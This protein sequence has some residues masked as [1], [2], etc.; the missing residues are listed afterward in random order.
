MK[1]VDPT[2]RDGLHALGLAKRAGAVA[3]GTRA[4]MDAA[5][6]GTLRA[7]IVSGDATDNARR[8]LA[9]ALRRTPGVVYGDRRQLGAALGRGPVVVVGL[10]DDGLAQRVIAGLAAAH[11]RTVG[12]TRTPDQ[13]R[14]P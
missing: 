9:P 12:S 14:G 2:G 13:E 3:V 4:V 7:V 11:P 10:T 6:A 1:R 8:R 5:R